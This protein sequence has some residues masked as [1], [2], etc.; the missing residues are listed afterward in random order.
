MKRPPIPIIINLIILSVGYL[1]CIYAVIDELSGGACSSEKLIAFLAWLSLT[2][3]IIGTYIAIFKCQSRSIFLLG[4]LL[5]L[6]GF[7]NCTW[8][9]SLGVVKK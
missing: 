2:L 9:Y 3:Y 6:G 4:V 8:P 1:C 7:I 5:L